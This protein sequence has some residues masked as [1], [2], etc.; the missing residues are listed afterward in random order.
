VV[1]GSVTSKDLSEGKEVTTLG[2]G[3]LKFTLGGG[4]KVNGVAIK[5]TD[6]AASNGIIHVIKG[7]LA[8]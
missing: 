2:G 4:A 5:K 1:S 3:T 8:P 6:I 7:V